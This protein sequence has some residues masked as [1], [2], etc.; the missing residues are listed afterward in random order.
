MKRIVM[1]SAVAVWMM[2]ASTAYARNWVDFK[3]TFEQ[4]LGEATSPT[5]TTLVVKT[6]KVKFTTKDMISVLEAHY[7]GDVYPVGSTLAFDVILA[8][9]ETGLA[10]PEGVTMGDIEVIDPDGN[11]LREV[12]PVVFNHIRAFYLGELPPPERL[13]IVQGSMSTVSEDSKKAYSSF[14]GYEIFVP[15]AVGP[16]IMVVGIL[17]EQVKRVQ[18]GDFVLQ[19]ASS[20]TT[21][22]GEGI[23]N[24]LY[25][26]V[27][28][29]ILLKGSTQTGIIIEE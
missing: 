18:K 7:V 5:P 12:D 1:L 16:K 23:C 4:Q 26:L 10:D 6:I 20:K 9:S 28:G 22:T 14:G 21:V 25:T 19:T 2:F 13:E 15:G 11:V 17:R 27:S 3:L 24:D 8:N 29:Q